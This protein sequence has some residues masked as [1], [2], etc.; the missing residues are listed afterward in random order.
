MKC[1]ATHTGYEGDSFAWAE[2]FKSLCIEHK[3]QFTKG[4]HLDAF[5]DLVDEK[6]GSGWFCKDKEPRALCG[7]LGRNSG[8]PP[9]TVVEDAQC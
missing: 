1:F 5:I 8:S 7:K 3:C 4:L 6:S 2:E 9:P